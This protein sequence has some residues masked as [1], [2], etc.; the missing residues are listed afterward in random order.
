MALERAPSARF[1]AASVPLQN[2]RE[3]LAYRLLRIRIARDLQ[4][5]H[6]TLARIDPSHVG[7]QQKK[8]A[9]T[10]Q[11]ETQPKTASHR[12]QAKTYAAV[13]KLL[14]GV[15]GSYEQMQELGLVEKDVELSGGIE[16]RLLAERAQRCDL[17]SKCIYMLE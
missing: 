3:F 1:E 6:Q 2:T 15:I 11:A 12:K 4:L 16:T 10:Q 9:N 17:H 5:V 8:H 14:D 7:N 13:V